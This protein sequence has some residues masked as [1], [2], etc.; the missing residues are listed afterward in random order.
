M[1]LDIR[2]SKHK[3]KIIIMLNNRKNLLKKL[4]TTAKKIKFIL[5]KLNLLRSTVVGQT[6][7]VSCIIDS[8]WSKESYE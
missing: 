4:H 3:K 7:K 5:Q 2:N 6:E 1:Y 8:Q